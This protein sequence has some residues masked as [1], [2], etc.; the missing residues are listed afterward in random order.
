MWE[1]L[2]IPPQFP[3]VLTL[4][5]MKSWSGTCIRDT[6]NDNVCYRVLTVSD[7]SPIISYFI[8]IQPMREV[9]EGISIPIFAKESLE[10]YSG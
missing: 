6:N 8:P 1:A 3:K 4:R 2:H 7:P 10:T 5:M 9:S